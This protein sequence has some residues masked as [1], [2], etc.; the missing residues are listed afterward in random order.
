M[1][2]SNWSKSYGD[3]VALDT[4]EFT[5]GSASVKVTS[6]INARVY[7]DIDQ[8][9]LEG[10]RGSFLVDVYVPD[11]DTVQTITF[12][13]WKAGLGGNANFAIGSFSTTGR[14]PGWY[15]F[16]VPY[17][18]MT[19]STFTIPDDF[20]A[21][22]RFSVDVAPQANE[23]AVV[24]IDNV[25]HVQQVYKPCIVLAF[26]D[27]YGSAFD[28]A[29]VKMDEYGFPGVVAIIGENVDAQGKLSTKHLEQMHGAGWDVISHHYAQGVRMTKSSAF[30]DLNKVD[31]LIRNVTGSKPRHMICG[32]WQAN[33]STI[34]K[35]KQ[36]YD[37]VGHLAWTLGTGMFDVLPYANDQRPFFTA[38]D[39]TD[40]LETLEGLI[41]GLVLD[42]GV[43]IL[44]FH[45]L[46]ETPSASTH[47]AIDDFNDLID[48]I[49]DLD[50]QIVT[51][52]QISQRDLLF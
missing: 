16:V 25:R 32:G 39:S 23:T 33:T 42:G 2:E 11:W 43:L 40:T 5:Q 31:R 19:G 22:T 38:I 52:T 10:A 34:W 46:V 8:L 26:H 18:L 7:K 49:A 1:C 17:S 48:Y 4:S 47:W 14:L 30:N 36:R 3:A 13:V 27:A 21:I 50:V 35:L 15:T 37:T 24:Y 45:D 20:A 9:D 28:V 44:N 29:K 41:D 12:R 6:T 51:F